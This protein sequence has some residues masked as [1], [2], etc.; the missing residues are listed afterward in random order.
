MRARWGFGFAAAIAVSVVPVIGALAAKAPGADK[1]FGMA[2][3][4]ANMLPDGSLYTGTGVVATS[5]PQTGQYVIEFNRDLRA[6]QW[7]VSSSDGTTVPS[8]LD[9][10]GGATFDEVIVRTNAD[11]QG[12]LA[13]GAFQLLVFCAR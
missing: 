7:V 3:L 5:K 6:C 1:T 4:G 2:I 8:A 11:T 12:H 9:I 13:D 10:P